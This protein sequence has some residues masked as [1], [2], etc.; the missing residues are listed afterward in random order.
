M[1]RG[2]PQIKSNASAKVSLGLDRQFQDRYGYAQSNRAVVVAQWLKRVD[3]QAMIGE[4][5]SMKVALGIGTLRNHVDGSKHGNYILH[6]LTKAGQASVIEFLVSEHAFDVNVQREGD[7]CTCLHLAAWC[8]N[9]EMVTMLRDVLGADTSI[10]NKYGENVETM[11]AN[12]THSSFKVKNQIQ[13]AKNCDGVLSIVESVLWLSA[14]P[15]EIAMALNRIAKFAVRWHE[16]QDDQRFKKLL[17]SCVQMIDTADADVLAAIAAAMVHMPVPCL[18]VKLA[19][20][21]AQRHRVATFSGRQLAKLAANIPRS[22]L[23][24][25]MRPIYEV[26]ADVASSQI[27]DMHPAEI[28]AI[29]IALGKA[30]VRH[31]GFFR[32][33]IARVFE[34]DMLNRLDLKVLSDVIWSLGRVRMVDERYIFHNEDISAALASR[35]K[36]YSD[37]DVSNMLW[38]FATL[39]VKN[40][41][42]LRPLVLQ[43]AR[44]LAAACFSLSNSGFQGLPQLSAQE[45][46]LLFAWQV[47]EKLCPSVLEG[48]AERES[49]Q[50]DVHA[51]SSVSDIR[52]TVSGLEDLGSIRELDELLASMDL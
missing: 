2:F 34:V 31:D 28:A 52:S 43:A 19:S 30:R 23:G 6:T 1:R 44:I 38:A 13:M 35:A 47:Y 7:G 37:D 29:C 46:Q 11:L 40:E 36:F 48:L 5:E 4:F 39:K 51:R 26:I 12:A 20:L 45:L 33:V 24:S 17:E 22:S 21:P 25:D 18:L 8:S 16:F 42:L 27:G 41:E 3:S 10:K 32:L 9:F 49:L 50:D 15:I 14:N